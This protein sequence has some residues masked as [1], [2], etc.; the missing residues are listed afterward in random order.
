[1]N[2][3]GHNYE[4]KQIN[5]GIINKNIYMKLKECKIMS[6]Q[7]IKYSKKLYIYIFVK[8]YC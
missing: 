2:N 6:G 7:F 4:F 8:K 1:M 5:S 3:H